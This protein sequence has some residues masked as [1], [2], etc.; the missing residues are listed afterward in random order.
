MFLEQFKPKVIDVT[1]TRDRVKLRLG[2]SKDARFWMNLSF[3]NM[4]QLR[5]FA[6]QINHA[7]VR[8]PQEYR[9]G[10]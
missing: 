9:S 10:S 2:E 3:E 6:E 8:G 1:A 7:I 5:D 4:D